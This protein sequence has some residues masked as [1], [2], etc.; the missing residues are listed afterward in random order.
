M[1]LIKSSHA[2]VPPLRSLL[3]DLLENDSIYGDSFF[4]K[5]WTPGVS[6]KD[7]EKDYEIGTASPGLKKE[8]FKLE[9]EKGVLTISGE[10][11]S[12]KEAKDKKYTRRGFSYNSFSRSF[13]LL[14]NVDENDIKA[15]YEDGILQLVLHKTK[16]E[17]PVKRPST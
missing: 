1:S 2:L 3:S 8:D 16:V 11:K 12:Q 7:N 17:K 14:E 9:V 10:S 6:V 5:D 4:C 15:K 13:L